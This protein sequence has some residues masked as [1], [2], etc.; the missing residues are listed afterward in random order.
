MNASNILERFEVLDDEDRVRSRFVPRSGSHF[1]PSGTFGVLRENGQLLLIINYDQG[2]PDGRFADFWSNGKTA[3]EGMFRNG[4]Q[5][6]IWQFYK[7]DGSVME[8]LH[9]KDGNATSPIT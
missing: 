4:K 6:G 9:F 2:I 7:D 1:L 3:C 5:D 8:V